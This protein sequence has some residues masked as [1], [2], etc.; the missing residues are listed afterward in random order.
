MPVIDSI[1]VADVEAL[2]AAVAPDRELHESR[3]YL[4]KGPFELPSVDPLGDQTNDVGTPARLVAAW[5]VG[6]GCR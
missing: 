4:W 1:A 3:K 6:M 2:L 5:T